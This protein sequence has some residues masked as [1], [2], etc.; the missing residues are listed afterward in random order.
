MQ[1]GSA[2]VRSRWPVVA[3]AAVLFAACLVWRFL[4]FDGFSNDHYA[5]LALAQQMLLGDRPVRDF[6]DPGWPLTYLLSAIA[7]RVWG[8]AMGTEWALTAGALSIGAAC[9][10]A[11]AYRLS[12]SLSI[13]VLVTVIEIL[14]YPRS[15][16]YPKVLAYA[17]GACALLAVVRL[18]S[19]PARST[20]RPQW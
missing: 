16:A 14:I 18:D 1:V 11:A 17:V 6:Y 12:L 20:A 9:T 15:Y 3:A 13:A 7:W 2:G 5:H 10:V 4:T 19:A 8:S